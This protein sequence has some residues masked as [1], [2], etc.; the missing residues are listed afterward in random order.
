MNPMVKEMV[1]K[2]GTKKING[3]RQRINKKLD[4]T[5]GTENNLIKIKQTLKESMMS[6]RVKETKSNQSFASLP[7]DNLEPKEMIIT[8]FIRE[9]NRKQSKKLKKRWM[10]YSKK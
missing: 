10:V 3:F 6:Y 4:S 9:G 5:T 8:R 7:S 2:S 1:E